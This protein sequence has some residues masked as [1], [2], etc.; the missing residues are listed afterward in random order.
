MD[1]KGMREDTEK[2]KGHDVSGQQVSG[3]EFKKPPM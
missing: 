1:L 3:W 2:K